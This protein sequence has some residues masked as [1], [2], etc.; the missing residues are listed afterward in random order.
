EK[1]KDIWDRSFLLRRAS[2]RAGNSAAFCLQPG[3]RA[4]CRNGSTDGFTDLTMAMVLALWTRLTAGGRRTTCPPRERHRADPPAVRPCPRGPVRR[5]CVRDLRAAAVSA[6]VACGAGSTR[7]RAGGGGAGKSAR[8]TRS[9]LAGSPSAP[10]T[11]SAARLRGGAS[12][13]RDPAR[14]AVHRGGVSVASWE[15]LQTDAGAPTPRVFEARQRLFGAS[16]PD[17]K[18][19]HD[20]AGWCPHCMMSWVALE[21]M[22]VPYAMD[23]TPLRAYLK[24]REKKRQR[25]VPVL[26]LLDD[27]QS[28]PS[29]WAFQ[30]AMQGVGRGEQVCRMLVERY[31]A[32]GLWPQAAA[33]RSAAEDHFELFVH[34][35]Q[36]HSGYKRLPGG[37]PTWG[38]PPARGTRD[39]RRERLIAALDGLEAALGGA[40]AQGGPFLL[41]QKP[42]M[43]DL[44]MLVILERVE[45]LLLHPLLGGASGLL[46]GAW[47]RASGLLAAGRRPGV[48]SF[49]ELCSDAETLLAI[50]L[51]EDP[52]RTPALPLQDTLLRPRHTLQEAARAAAG[53]RRE[54]CAEAAARVCARHAAVV[55]FACCGRGCGRG[56]D[57]AKAAAAAYPSGDGD[58]DV[59]LA[60]RLVVAAL[61][62]P[63]GLERRATELEADARRAARCWGS[64]ASPA[65]LPLRFL[66]QNV[67]VPR[68]MAA[69]P[70]AALRAHLNLLVAAL[71]GGAPPKGIARPRRAGARPDHGGSGAPA[72][73]GDARASGA[74]EGRAAE[75]GPGAAGLQRRP[76]AR[77][78][79]VEPSASG[80]GRAGSRRASFGKKSRIPTRAPAEGLR[81]SQGAARASQGSY[82]EV[83]V[84]PKRDIDI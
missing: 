51:R 2:E 59:D 3:G 58:P 36:A 52:G 29:S 20:A 53:H 25:L 63:G 7:K 28:S 60:L 84:K 49:G 68:D 77:I 61:L 39:P 41:G 34:L 5:A 62:V 12:R 66:A 78:A 57:E 9:R 18:F 15:D 31:P 37:R 19:W 27:G 64:R 26:Q 4:P 79:R 30:D 44:M 56:A 82:E 14:T 23:T 45:A 50:S 40:A 70:A 67:G 54:A 69:E 8:S 32:A 1:D 74:P 73:G 47:P 43:V 38:V 24:P 46:L 72:A 76:P 21:E 42:Y 71:E 75:G 80:A 22:K 6:L 10:H 55:A 11:G 83:K 81:S 13:R 65:L 16:V 35:Q 17:L 33:Q 48:C